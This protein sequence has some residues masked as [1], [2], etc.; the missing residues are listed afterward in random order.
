MILTTMLIDLR[1][2]VVFCTAEKMSENGVRTGVSFSIPEAQ[3]FAK[4]EM[5]GRY[6][7][8]NQDVLAIGSELFG[9]P[10]N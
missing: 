6:T 1:S 2:C 7:W 8:D 5:D 4:A 3:L 10:I 9:Q